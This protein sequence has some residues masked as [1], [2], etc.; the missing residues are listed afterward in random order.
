MHSLGHTSIT[1]ATKWLRLP[2][3]NIQPCNFLMGVP[4]CYF[5]NQWP[6]INRQVI[7]CGM[8]TALHVSGVIR[9]ASL[10][11]NCSHTVGWKVFH[12]SGRRQLMFQAHTILQQH[13]W[14]QIESN[15]SVYS[16]QYYTW[17]IVQHVKKLLK[18]E[19]K[20]PRKKESWIQ[21]SKKPGEG[22][23]QKNPV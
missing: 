15:I 3:S 7:M 1:T 18:I 8:W 5:E 22:Y 2:F 14:A 19:E 23:K 13:N 21:Y 4:S 10:V 9:V 17:Y 16:I 12:T 6:I 20:N 11:W